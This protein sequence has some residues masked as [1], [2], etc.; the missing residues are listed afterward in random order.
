MRRELLPAD[1]GKPRAGLNGEAP[2]LRHQPGPGPEEEL[3][4]T[5]ATKKATK[6][7]KKGKR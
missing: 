7:S 6:K 3:D 4:P 2:N 1:R 5:M